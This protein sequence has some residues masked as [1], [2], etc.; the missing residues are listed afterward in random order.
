MFDY[1]ANWIESIKTLCIGGK[2]TGPPDELPF[3]P[4]PLYNTP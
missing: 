4:K 3:Y 1:V 2:S